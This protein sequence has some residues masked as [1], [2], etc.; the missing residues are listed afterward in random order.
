[1]AN[2]LS[3]LFV[4]LGL[5]SSSFNKGIDSAQKKTNGFGNGLKKIG[6][7]IAGAFAIGAVVSFG[8][9]LIAIGGIAEGVRDAFNRIADDKIL[10]GLKEAT[11]GTVSELELMKR[12][13]TAQNLGVPIENLASLFEFATKRAQDTGESV[14]FLVDSI[15]LGIGRKSPLILDNLGISAIA[16]K[17]KMDGVAIGTAS[18]ADVAKAVGDIAAESMS[19][20]G[21]IIDTNAVKVANLTAKWEDLKLELAENPL[22]NDTVGKALDFLNRQLLLLPQ[23]LEISK[24]ALKAVFGADLGEGI[25]AQQKA[26]AERAKIFNERQ[27][28][29]QEGA[30]RRKATIDRLNA[31]LREE[32]TTIGDLEKEIETLEDSLKLLGINEEEEIERTNFLIKV[33]KRQLEGLLGTTKAIDFEAIAVKSLTDALAEL[34]ELVG[35]L[36][37]IDDK[38][39]SIFDKSIG[40][41]GLGAVGI[42]FRPESE[43]DLSAFDT[44]KF[45]E[46]LE[47]QKVEAQNFVDGMN[48][49]LE[50]G[51][52]NMIGTLA[53]GFGRLAVGDIGFDEFGNM[54]LEQIGSFLG[55][56]GQYLI[57]Y[58]FAMEAFK[59]AFTNPF[60]AIAAGVA[61]VAIGGAI[62]G[63]ASKGVSSGNISPSGGAGGSTG[64]FNQGTRAEDNRVVF[65]LEGTKLI[66]VMQNTNRRRGIIA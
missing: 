23:N 34:F 25:S 4:K 50:Q 19:K 51:V 61:L 45:A 42:S 36:E 41:V 8:K 3:D 38:L 16:L 52:E 21:G 37:D 24:R 13:V 22:V 7:L 29:A 59:K 28:E 56:M 44:E 64:G 40:E 30:K 14:D 46:H 54:V 47:K 15:V 43:E 5:N 6:G 39:E 20:S 62:S 60:L 55:Q 58:G 18:V 32:V 48:D 63:L 26:L 11:R 49:I 9:E 31:A 1:M 10:Q 2:K 33:K 53:E 57:A 65:E 27:K 66:G 35:N 17:E 12:A